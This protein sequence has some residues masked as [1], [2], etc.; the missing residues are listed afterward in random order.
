MV[1]F[2]QSK[3]SRV[4]LPVP[5]HTAVW[6][7]HPESG[8]RCDRVRCSFC[9]ASLR[10]QI[11][12]FTPYSRAMSSSVASLIESG[13]WEMVDLGVALPCFFLGTNVQS[14]SA[15]VGVVYGWWAG[16]YVAARAKSMS[17]LEAKLYE[18]TRSCSQGRY[19]SLH[20]QT[21]VEV[22]RCSLVT[23]DS[24]LLPRRSAIKVPRTC[25]YVGLS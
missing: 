13:V 16:C 8:L 1:L 10:F 7:C 4:K 22:F 12:L 15:I 21:L 11:R 20:L 25:S 18:K 6:I 3:L 17:V 14:S 2:L 5:R 24:A 19:T 9:R 23:T